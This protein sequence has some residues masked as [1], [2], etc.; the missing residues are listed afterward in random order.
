LKKKYSI[1]IDDDDDIFVVDPVRIQILKTIPIGKKTIA[2]KVAKALDIKRRRGLEFL[3]RLENEGYL[4]S[5]YELLKYK[6]GRRARAR[7]F[8]RIK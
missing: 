3:D 4:E 1:T 8:K 5:K 7:V 6:S 2:S